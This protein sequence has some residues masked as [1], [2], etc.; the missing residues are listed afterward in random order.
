MCHIATF[1]SLWCGQY[2]FLNYTERM[3]ET[4][5]HRAVIL[6]G[7]LSLELAKENRLNFILK[8]GSLCLYRSG[9]CFAHRTIGG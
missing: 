7:N 6:F 8:T 4:I 9:S 2:K 5:G 1:S 3:K